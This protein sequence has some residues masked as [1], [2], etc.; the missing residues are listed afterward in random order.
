MSVDDILNRY[1]PGGRV[2]TVEGY[3]HKGQPVMLT[4]FGG[5][6]FVEPE[7]AII[8]TWGYSAV[9]SSQEFRRRYEELMNAIHRIELFTGFCY[10]QFTDTFQEANGLF[11]ADRTPKFSLTAMAV[12]L[13]GLV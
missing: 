4:E 2:I 1:R 6:A 7:D 13:E 11:K 12:P 5:I 10:T 9:K 8:T 3:S